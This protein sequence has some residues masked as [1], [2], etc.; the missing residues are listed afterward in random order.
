[1]ENE[2][3]SAPSDSAESEASDVADALMDLQTA[4]RL[5]QERARQISEL[6]SVRDRLVAREA[7]LATV[8][9]E[10]GA[11]QRAREAEVRHLQTRIEQLERLY[12]E[13]LERDQRIASLEQQLDAA[14]EEAA[15]RAAG[16][17]ASS[18][19]APSPPTDTSGPR[20]YADWERWF[21]ERL[22]EH[23]DAHLTRLEETIRRQHEV[24]VEKEARIADLMG[25][26]EPESVGGPDDLKRIKG[27]GPALEKLLHEMG[28][29]SFQQLAH[30]DEVE[31][32]LIAGQLNAFRD[33]IWRD[34]WIEQARLLAGS[35]YAA[36]EQD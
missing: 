25:R 2:W 18:P 29:T 32:E 12:P 28:I 16:S 10:L 30:L 1:V 20:P 13:L 7:R 19:E 3:H 6:E 24:L 8:E 33:R 11:L 23:A 9:A 36:V 5:L 26:L 14:I 17:G 15:L 21:R 31:A 22:A 27:I 4:R 34:G 35:Y